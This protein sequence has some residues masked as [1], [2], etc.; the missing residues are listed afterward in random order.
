M[1]SAHP[2]A[3]RF[4][5]NRVWTYPG[6]TL[7]AAF[8]NTTALVNSF[9]SYRLCYQGIGRAKCRTGRLQGL[10]TETLRIRVVGA[11]VPCRTRVIRVWWIVSGRT[12]ARDTAWVFE[13][14]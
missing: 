4:R 2:R 5:G 6:D 13:C 1:R 9:A 3:I 11:W 12:V 7:L 14:V 10:R 8:R